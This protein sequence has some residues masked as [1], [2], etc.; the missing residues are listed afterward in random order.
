[1]L[2]IADVRVQ[3]GHNLTAAEMVRNSGTLALAGRLTGDLGNTGTLALE[4]G[5]VDGSVTSNGQ[6]TGAGRITGTLFNNADLT[7]NDRLRVGTLQNNRRLTVA[8][9]RALVADEAVVNLGTFDLLGQLQGNLVNEA[10]HVANL[11]AGP[12]ITAR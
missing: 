4:R 7:L 2:N 10:G 8:R 5:V 11:G 3:E 9:G 12:P 1:M 6:I